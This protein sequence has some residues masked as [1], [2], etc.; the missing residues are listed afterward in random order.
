MRINNFFS[1]IKKPSHDVVYTSV[2]NLF[3]L[4]ITLW[5]GNYF[6][7]SKLLEIDQ[8]KTEQQNSIETKNEFVK[9]FTKLIQSRIYL[10]ENYYQNIETRENEDVLNRS[11][12]NYMDSVRLWNEENLLNPIFIKYYFGDEMQNEFYSEVQPK[13]VNLHNSLLEIRDGKKVENIKEIV[14]K[15]KHEAFIYSEKLMFNNQR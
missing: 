10:S 1:R 13:L 11:W 9:K 3:I 7:G 5:I 14:E 8:K 2:F 6:I 4:I 12:E 15:A